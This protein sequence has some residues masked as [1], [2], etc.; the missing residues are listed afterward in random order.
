MRNSLLRALVDAASVAANI[1]KIAAQAATPSHTI[2]NTS[3]TQPW[4]TQRHQQQQQQPIQEQEQEQERDHQHTV[5][6]AVI[7]PS[8]SPAPP[9][10][11][12]QPPQS[13]PEAQSPIIH[14]ALS[15]KPD[16]T[17]TQTGKQYQPS[18]PSQPPPTS[19]TPPPPPIN[20]PEPVAASTAP[21]PA[22][23]PV[24]DYDPESA[25]RTTP[26]RAAKVPSSRIGRLIHYG[27][28]GAGLAWGAAGQYVSRSASA[29]G[30]GNAFMGEPN[31]RRLVDKLSTMRG[32]ALKMG[33]FMSIQEVLLRVQNSANYMPEWQM[34]Q[35]MQQDLGPEWRSKFD[36][37]NP[38]PF[39]A[40]SIG[41]VHSAVLSSSSSHPLAGCKVAVKIQF[42]GIK[43]SIKSDLGY[44]STL[45]TASALLPPGLF[46]DK[47]I[48]T[49]RGELE[50][51]CDYVRE[52]DMGRRFAALLD[53]VQGNGKGSGSGVEGVMQFAVPKVV[54]Q[55]CTGRVL[56]TEMMRG[57]P[58]T[59][60]ARYTQE[61]RNQ[62]ATSVLR[63]CLQELFQFRLMQTDPNWSNF[64]LNERTS[65]LELLDFGATREYTPLFIDQLFHLLSAAVS[66]D[67]ESCLEWSR[68]IGYLNG[69]ESDTMIE[70]H[71]ESM[72]LLAE[73]FSPTSPSPY[74]FT[75]QTI[76]SRVRA[77]IP[78][79]LRERK[80]PP[81]RETYSLNRKLSGAFLLCARLGAEVRCREVWEEVVRAYRARASS[82]A[83][84]G[85]QGERA[86]RGLH[87]LALGAREGGSGR[88]RPSLPIGSPIMSH[89]R[90]RHRLGPDSSRSFST[91]SAVEDGALDSGRQ[92]TLDLR[93]HWTRRQP[94]QFDEPSPA[95]KPRAKLDLP[96]D[97]LGIDSPS[98]AVDG[99]PVVGPKKAAEEAMLG[100]L[101]QGEGG[102]EEETGPKPVWIRGVMVPRRPPPPG[103]EDC[104][105]SGCVHCTYDIYADAIQDYL[106]ALD[107]A[108]SSLLSMRSPPL[109]DPEWSL[110]G[111]LGI[112]RPVAQESAEDEDKKEAEERAKR[113]V[114]EAV[115]AVAD[116]T[117]RAFLAMER[118]LTTKEKMERREV[119]RELKRK[120]EEGE[121]QGLEE[122]QKV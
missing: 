114:D 51:E 4:P 65:T 52:A 14:K 7:P 44:L 71:L 57:R 108:R 59:Q 81:P 109:T 23:T 11:Q 33:Q 50:D 85:G 3:T 45:L 55:L 17:S 96:L 76:T 34:Q 70:A 49:M 48:E 16:P 100:A 118:R 78:V 101:G 122:G 93:A 88:R 43:Q 46:L 22:S 25:P 19:T 20:R 13:Q 119:R 36:H 80:R 102:K 116:P 28:L 75:N 84:A 39:A 38:I 42:P 105:M 95:A 9:P 90:I 15:T 86:R 24:D 63:L 26:L 87:T 103:P 113:E 77:H 107:V 83:G 120:E 106:S 72:L 21:A 54:D 30:S 117:L 5:T 53:G 97:P 68:K 18:P 6:P 58:L 2:T 94:T 91:T 66:R 99:G 74:N 47:T 111:E 29:S 10:L 61:R 98:P 121:G 60:A 67:R 37:F 62:I 92:R 35:V 82:S 41:Q 40:A 79:M 104:C 12:P 73:P 112:K 56:T 110:A 27:S 69:E 31:L 89:P 1:T 64:L 115:M 8:H 32:A